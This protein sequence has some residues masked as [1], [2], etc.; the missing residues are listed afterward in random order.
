LRLFFKISSSTALNLLKLKTESSFY[1]CAEGFPGL[2]LEFM[3]C[4]KSEQGQVSKHLLNR[5]KGPGLY[6]EQ[7]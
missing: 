6:M 7:F 5:Q 1:I 4:I 2:I 3:L